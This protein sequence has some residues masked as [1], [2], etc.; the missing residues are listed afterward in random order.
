ML[1]GGQVL[2]N[3]FTDKVFRRGGRNAHGWGSGKLMRFF[4]LATS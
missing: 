4:I 2:V 1:A 3:D